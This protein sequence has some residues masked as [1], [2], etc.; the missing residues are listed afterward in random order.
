M[1]MRIIIALLVSATAWGANLAPDFR[2]WKGSP[3][4]GTFQQQRD[5]RSVPGVRGTGRKDDSSAW[6]TADLKLPPGGTYGLRFQAEVSESGSLISGLEGVNRDFAVSAGSFAGGFAFRVSDQPGPT[7][8]RLGHWQLKGEAI[9]TNAVLYPVQPVHCRWGD[10]EL[11]DGERIDDGV[12]SDRHILN[13]QGSTIH[14]TLHQQ[15]AGFNSDR[16][17]FFA[18]GTQVTY[19]HELPGEM[20]DGEVKVTLSYYVAGTLAV[21]ASKD[22]INWTRFAQMDGKKDLTAR[23]PAALFPAR[24]IYVRLEAEGT[25]VNLQAKAYTFKAKTSLAMTR[26]GRTL[27]IEESRMAPDLSVSAEGAEDGLLLRWRNAAGTARKLDLQVAAGSAARGDCVVRIPAHGE[28]LVQIGLGSLAEAAG[29]KVAAIQLPLSGGAHTVSISAKEGRETVAEL[30]MDV[31]CSV[32]SESAYG[33]PCQGKFP[34]VSAWWCEGAWKVGAARGVPD[35]QPRGILIEAARGEFEAA[36]LVLNAGPAGAT[37]QAIEIGELKGRKGRIPGSAIRVCEIA[38]VKVE[39]PSD[40]LGGPGDYP[41]PLPPLALPLQLPASRN[42]ALW[43][44]VRV[45]DDTPAG[46]YQGEI[47]LKTAAGT[48]SVA[49]QIQ[50]FDFTLPKETHLRSGFGINHQP[51][52]RYH[53]LKTREQELAVYEKY[54]QSFAEHRIAPYSFSAYSPVQVHFEGQGDARKVIIDWK[55]F[56]AAARKYLDSGWFNAFS[57]PV[58]GLGGG[59]FFERRPGEFG[60]FKFGTPDYERLWGDYI[61]QVEAH[62]RGNGWLKQAYVY[63]FDEP[64]KK[65]YEFV[66]ERMKKLKTAAP[67]LTRLLTEQPEPELFGNV[68]LWCALTPHWTPKLVQE[69]RAAGEEIWWYICCGPKAPY[70]GEFIEHPA[71]E[72]RLWPWQSWQYGVQ[73]ILIWDTAYWTSE[74]AFPD[75]LQDPWRDPMSYVVGYGTPKGTRQFW[76]NGDG[77]YLYPPRRDPNQPAEPCLDGPVSSLR[78]ENLRDGMEDYEYLWL[79]KQQIERVKAKADARLLTEA[80]ALL[81]VPGT[82]SKDTTHFTSDVRPLLEQR[83][84]IAAMIEK[85]QKL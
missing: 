13:W 34:G 36:Q 61:R 76:G 38:T 69:R 84:K 9:F 43:I 11:G 63:W 22:G 8:L 21:S 1:I 57:F 77:R 79:L 28:A 70:V 58:Q 85:L 62:L 30:A 26:A 50:V 81:M 48:G 37:L 23:L 4:A 35:G 78:W 20:L 64:D 27:L 5:G 42:Q 29:K 47:K 82:I 54:L 73:G 72:M 31:T 53:Q 3:P 18:A 16:W 45:P 33:Y 7:V 40:Y 24:T 74:T 17:C 2:D 71:V 75:S 6:R 83:R 25:P 67:G 66:N 60:G 10:L 68:D 65:D 56:D 12:Y 44:L 49:L 52:K 19:K 46:H 80:Q 51:V 41:D 39:N 15:K 55:S 59:T 32:L 14:R